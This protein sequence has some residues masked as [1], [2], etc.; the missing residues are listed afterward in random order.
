LHRLVRLV[1]PTDDGGGTE[2]YSGWTNYYY[3]PGSWVGD[4]PGFMTGSGM[5]MRFSAKTGGPVDVY[6]AA[7][8]MTDESGQSYPPTPDSLLGNA[9]GPLGY[10][11]AFVANEH[12][13]SSTEFQSDQLMASASRTAWPV[14]SSS[15]LLTW[16]D[17]RNARRTPARPGR[18]TRC[19]SRSTSAPTG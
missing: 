19:P 11:C 3:G 7:T 10:Y 12:T 17:G 2:R 14:V 9:T 18:V 1:E 15:Q 5:P 16:L 4:R 8:Q 13:D 6:Q